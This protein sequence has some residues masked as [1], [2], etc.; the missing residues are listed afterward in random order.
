MPRWLPL[1]TASKFWRLKTPY[2]QTIHGLP[3]WDR[4]LSIFVTVFTN[5]RWVRLTSVE[6]SLQK[7]Q[8]QNQGFPDAFVVKF[9]GKTWEEQ[10]VKP[11]TKN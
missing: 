4:W 1:P 9:E 11:L 5:T 6:A 10:G 3:M 7:S 8:I 2:P